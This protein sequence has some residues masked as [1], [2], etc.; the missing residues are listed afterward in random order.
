MSQITLPTTTANQAV[1]SVA[2]AQAALPQLKIGDQLMATVMGNQGGKVQLQTPHGTLSARSDLPLQNGQQLKLTVAQLQ[3]QVTLSIQKPAAPPT[4]ALGQRVAP[5]Q[6][7]LQQALQNLSQ[8]LQNPATPKSG[9]EAIQ[10][11]LQ[12]L[13]ILTQLFDP[14]NIKDQ[15]SKSGNFME[16]H[17]LN[18]KSGA[19]KG[20]LKSQLLSMKTQLLNQPDQQKV[21]KQLDA[22]IARI[23]MNQLKSLQSQGQTQGQG[24]ADQGSAKEA[25]SQRNWNVE[26]P[27][28]VDDQLQELALKFRQQQTGEDEES[29]RWHVELN[30]DPPGL[31]AIQAHAIYHQGKLDI[32]FLTE[33]QQTAHVISD[34]MELLQSSLESAGVETGTLF[35]RQK[36]VNDP[37]QTDL[38]Y[39]S[40]GFSIKA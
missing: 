1:L 2:K 7:P 35:S 9:Q 27:F 16:N 19:L 15:I 14:K 32:H 8:L 28:M 5:Q 33:Q 11:L 39:S 3:P 6:Q 18:N 4:E 38:P 37:V 30:L 10:R 31:G 20:D 23:E 22:M 24:G 26:I 17:L 12:Q 13:P 25:A 40:G 34:K 21:V 36:T 29:S